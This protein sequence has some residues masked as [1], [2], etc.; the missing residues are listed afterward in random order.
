MFVPDTDASGDAIGVELSQ[1]QEGMGK[2]IAY[3]SLSLRRDQR[4][5]CT[6]RKELLAVVRFTRMYRHYLLGSRFIVR[7]DHHSLIWLL[8]IKSSH[9]QL[10]R[11]LE[12]LNQYNMEIHH[13]PGRKHTNVD[14]MSRLPHTYG[15]AD[16]TIAVHL[17]DLP[18]GRCQKCTR[19][20]ESCHKFPEEVDDVASLARPGTWTYSPESNLGAERSENPPVTLYQCYP[21][22]TDS[23]LSSRAALD[24]VT[25][26]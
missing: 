16:T 14:A 8:N 17:K 5:Y 26:K 9:D 18:C 11:W 6:T 13:R 12:E 4:K 7:T 10:A 19:A 15:A 22:G 1:I 25:G 23:N 2:P 3:G 24:Y 20:H 21:G